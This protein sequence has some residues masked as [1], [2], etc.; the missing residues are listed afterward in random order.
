[1][2]G[3]NLYMV[4]G[5]VVVIGALFAFYYIQPG[6]LDAFAQCLEDKGAT[7]YGAFW[8]PHCA[9]QKRLFG[10]SETELPY[11]ECSTPDGQRQTQVCIDAGIQ[12]YPTWEFADG[13]RVTGVQQ[14]EALAERTACELPAGA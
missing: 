8:C 14:L 5:A 13:E 2:K 6:K 9:E 4:I 1:M 3:K 7:F 12:S 11:V 10:K